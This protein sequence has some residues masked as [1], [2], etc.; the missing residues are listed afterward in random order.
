VSAALT[1]TR[2]DSDLFPRPSRPRPGTLLPL[3]AWISPGSWWLSDDFW[4]R[5]EPLLPSPPPHNRGGRPRCD[6]RRVMSGIFYVLRTGCQWKALPRCFGAPSTV[7]ARFQQWREAGVFLRLWAAGLLAYDDAQGIAW[8]WQACDG[9]MTKAPLGG[10]ATGRNPTDRGK[11]GT[12]R[13]LLTDGRGQ[14]LGL[15]VAGANVNDHLLFAATLDSIPIPRPQPTTTDPQNLCIDK[16]YD[17]DRVRAAAQERDYT[18]HLR[19]RGEELVDK[20]N[21]PNYR[22]RRWVVER[23]HSWI[24]R[25]RRLLVRWEKKAENY[26]AFLHLAFA[27]HLFHAADRHPTTA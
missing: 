7:H 18:L 21:I 17:Y 19:T 22:A 25:F 16:G 12:K 5:I 23:T 4:A 26:V 6:D 14:P 3:A 20:R 27:Y 2:P 8:D 13:S 1:A 9:A 24:N 10:E 15:E 11:S